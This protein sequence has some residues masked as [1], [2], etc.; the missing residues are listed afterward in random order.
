[1]RKAIIAMV[2]LFRVT[3]WPLGGLWEIILR[4]IV[5]GGAEQ[6]FICPLCI[7]IIP[8]AGCADLIVKENR[9]KGK[10]E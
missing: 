5:G 4:P 2:I 3:V 7:G 6:S 9:S 1:M 8:A 10:N